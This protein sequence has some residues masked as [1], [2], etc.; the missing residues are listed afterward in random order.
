[1][2][3][4]QHLSLNQKKQLAAD[5]TRVLSLYGFI[6]DSYVI[7]FFSDNLWATLP[8]SW[9]LALSD[10]PSPQLADQ[11]LSNI[12]NVCYRS[13]WPLSLLALKATAHALSFPR[14]LSHEV[15]DV[16]SKTPKEFLENHCQSSM[17]DP[18][19]RKH[20]KPKKQHEIRQLGKLVK[21][22]SNLTGCDEV[23]DIGSGQ[24]HLSRFLAFGQ[25]LS[26]T[27]IEADKNLVDMAMKFDQHLIYMLQK[28]QSRLTKNNA[29]KL[30]GTVSS[31]PP[32]H[33]F[34]FVDPKASWGDLVTKFREASSVETEEHGGVQ[35]S[36][37]VS[38][39]DGQTSQNQ[40]IATVD[41]ESNQQELGTSQKTCPHN[42]VTLR[43]DLCPCDALNTANQWQFTHTN[44]FVLTGLHA[45]GDLSVATLRHFVRCPNVVGVTSV[46]CCYMKLTTCELPN[47]PG[48]LFASNTSDIAD[49][50]TQYGYPLSSW[51][52][53]LQG[54][55]LSYKA[56][57]VAC[58]AIEDYTE[59]L[60][61]ESTI[62][63]THCYR[64]VLETLIRSV[65]PNMK[66]AGVQ[67]IKKAHELS[68]K[69]YAKRGLKK[70]G[71]DPC[72]PLCESSVERMLSQQQNVVAFF[73]LALLLAPLVE[74]L[75]LLDRMIFV[76]EAGFHCDLIPLFKPQFSPRNLVLV[77]AKTKAHAGSLIEE[78][79]TIL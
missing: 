49:T 45:C 48:V 37:L 36:H 53:Q 28:E 15:G 61:G 44:K 33:V 3:G 4:F 60:R 8:Q 40:V 38:P 46:A 58:H 74:T 6:A 19:F 39:D 78:I 50:N 21:K 62:L 54:H 51:V 24:G 31:K 26:V 43:E 76:H 14:T 47:P 11:L 1:M 35:T 68:F 77:A 73:S 59:R 16:N 27:A 30:T 57:E 75:I 69:E 5:I 32:K 42:D 10:L 23:V 72:A 52:S 66:R 18:L 67:T 20:V 65:D 34:A 56:R 79:K 71:L 12:K 25:G 2:S 63:R 22:L 13:V 7:E 55:K 41:S 9:R 17:L 70:I 64:A 29:H